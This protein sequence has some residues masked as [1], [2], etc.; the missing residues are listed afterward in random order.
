VRLRTKTT[1]SEI[2][3]KMTGPAAG[4]HAWDC[5]GGRKRDIAVVHRVRRMEKPV[6]ETTIGCDFGQVAIG[7]EA[8]APGETFVEIEPGPSADAEG[9]APLWE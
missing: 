9:N 5:P 3:M 8:I 1:G 2:T 7:A 6:R 4:D